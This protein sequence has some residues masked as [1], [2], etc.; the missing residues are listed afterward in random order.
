MKLSNK[1]LSAAAMIIAMICIFSFKNFDNKKTI[2]IDAG[3]GGTDF[4]ATVNGISEKNITQQIANKIED[5]HLDSDT[6]E[7]LI[8]RAADEN[9]SIEDRAKM[10][11]QINPDLF[12]SLHINSSKNSADNGINAYVS[13]KTDNYQKS[14]VIADI[15]LNEVC[16]PK[17]TKGK[18]QDANFVVLKKTTCPA[19]LLEIGFMS[20]ENDLSY[21]S[22]QVGQT[23]I[24]KRIIQAVSK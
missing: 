3:H 10:V 1:I 23:E 9:M 7:I 11:N 15:L 5:L 17:L 16:S 19:V 4:G 8:I 22:N 24:A 21:I 14:K 20:N 2:V 13:P 6:F 12:V 18:V